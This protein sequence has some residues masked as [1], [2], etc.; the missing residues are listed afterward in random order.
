MFA[1]TRPVV[2]LLFLLSGCTGLIY[3][4]VWTRQ[5][6]LL[7]GGTTYAITTVL[8]AFMSGLALGSYLSGR[9][10]E[11]FAQPGRAYGGL[12][13]TVGAYA[14]LVPALL[15]IAEPLYRTLYP[16][17]AHLPGV[18]TGVR[19][20]VGAMVLLLPATCM[21]ATLPM[22]VRY[23]THGNSGLGRSA[24]LL[25]GINT[26]G[27]MFGTVLAGFLL[28]P[29]F[30]LTRTTWLTAGTNIVI[31]LLAIFVLRQPITSVA[32]AVAAGPIARKGKHQPPPAITANIRRIVLLVAGASGFAAM[33]YQIAW[34][35]ALIMSIGS[36][37]YAFTC[38]LAAFIL[39]LGLG[40]LAIARWA[41]R[42][43]R[44]VWLLAALEMGIGLSAI[45]IV[46]IH[47]RIPAVVQ[48]LV[49]ARSQD[50]ASLLWAEFALVIAVT[51][52][53]T[54]FMGAA[55]PLVTRI[56]GASGGEPA[57][58][59]GRA[60]AVNTLGTI[61]GAFLAGFVLIRGDV[62]GL[63]NSIV[64]AAL[65]NTIIGGY[66][67]IKSR[68]AGQ[69]MIRHAAFAVFTVL[70]V[71][72][73]ARLTGPWNR[74]LMT[75]GPF[76]DR[77][78][79]PGHRSVEYFF[80][81]V[82]T[83]VAV[84]RSGKP[85]SNLSLVINGKD[86]ASTGSL[87]L[88]T[89]LLLG[90]VP[91]LLDVHG[92]R[93]CVIGLGSGMTLAAVSRYPSYER[94][95]CVELS[96]GVTKSA[97]FFALYNYNVLHDDRRVNLIRAD[98]RNH[99]LLTDQ[100]YDLIISEPSNPWI[101]GVSNLFTREFFDL[102]RQRL[103]PQGHLAVWL[104][105]YSMSQADF[106]MVIRTLF[107]VF[108]SVSLWEMSPVDYCFVAGRG[109]GP[110]PLA[111]LVARYTQAPVAQD[112]YRISL[113]DLGGVL[114]K[115]VTTSRRLRAWVA[116]SPVHTDDNAL[117]EFSAPR[118]LYRS[119]EVPI[120]VA[121][122]ALQES[123]FDAVVEAKPGEPGVDEVKARTVATIES[124]RAYVAAR[125]R[126]QHQALAEALNMLITAYELDPGNTSL[127]R[128][129]RILVGSLPSDREP[130]VEL[131]AILE[132]IGRLPAPAIA[133]P[134]GVSREG[135][136]QILLSLANDSIQ[137][138]QW[139]AA[140]AYF[141]QARGLVPEDGNIAGLLA[142]TL[143]QAQRPDEAA[144]L[145]QAF[146]K[147][148]PSDGEANVV[149]SWLALQRNDVSSALLHC[150]RVLQSGAITTQQL[151]AHT[152]LGAF[153]DTPAFHAL[154]DRYA[155]TQPVYTPR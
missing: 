61:V 147:Q 63:Q 7:L 87:D 58:A 123:P 56:V 25:Y 120:L 139:S 116:G 152:I 84:V 112:L 80:E 111:Q 79:T 144:E 90:H 23:I 93:A 12:E 65:L 110:I 97:D 59:V 107:D 136:V 132:K 69:T 133:P 31:G 36:S 88:C 119:E 17:V 1:R 26:C 131:P 121:L 24:G 40:S 8:V 77:P 96:E 81:D 100:R 49:A 28:I 145:I 140:I 128:I 22:L 127:Y 48:Q 73:T 91:A 15:G 33:V 75:S 134:Q 105:S 82:D 86:D 72:V 51:F 102:C 141:R 135:M 57:A 55:F 3:E 38:I 150:E 52:V 6:I 54:F 103:T 41:D 95:D 104:H 92:K 9:W 151:E 37:T 71:A 143:A 149:A 13:I 115:F 2:Y 85:V 130:P 60:Y 114:G 44:P 89:Q 153:R 18:L 11:R 108:D 68:P 118:S 42:L 106:Q 66:L 29:T 122:A 148:Y 62:L 146:L 74:E 16:H 154:L 124:R 27:A 137:K 10:S 78:E 53:P 50:Y 129:L 21:G 113:L 142:M 5:L 76:M 47:G 34:T 94:I 70:I 64:V 35:R 155:A 109:N 4:L 19:F 39:G 43:S 30:G 32:R 101:A 99:L 98:G 83:T 14:L 20:C 117:L 46:P 125:D 67:L 126:W 45:F 138:Q